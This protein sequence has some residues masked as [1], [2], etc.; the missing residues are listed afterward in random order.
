L[1]VT[2]HRDAVVGAAERLG[3]LARGT[4][5]T[6]ATAESCT[7]G[8]VAAAITAVPGSSAYY[9][10]GIVSYADAAKIA[11]LDTDA[12]LMARN[13]AVSKQVVQAMAQGACRAL[14]ADVAVATSG[15][16][17]P[18]GGT[19]V[20]PI[21]T[22]WFGLCAFGET[23]A[24]CHW[25]EGDRESVQVQATEVALNLL[26]RGCRGDRGDN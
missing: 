17:G 16:A 8:R 26:G 23:I 21:G 20:K 14:Q 4:G 13:G 25:F 3:V 19:E 2:T 9:K 22:V 7:G 18:D 5:V 6:I 24:E 15:I 1:I 10:G 12:D 11:L